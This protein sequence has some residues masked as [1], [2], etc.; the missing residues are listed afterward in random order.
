MSGHRPWREVK[1]EKQ[2]RDDERGRTPIRSD[3]NAFIHTRGPHEGEPSDGEHVCVPECYEDTS[4]LMEGGHWVDPRPEYRVLA[5]PWYDHDGG[6]AGHDYGC[7]TGFTLEILV[8]HPDQLGSL[9]DWRRLGATQTESGSSLRVDEV[10]ALVVDYVA[11]LASPH[12]VNVDPTRITI[13][14]EVT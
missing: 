3:P 1:A 2:R 12:H 13:F 11:A 4:H 9:G 8:R 6:A 14:A 5:T 10:Y 7:V